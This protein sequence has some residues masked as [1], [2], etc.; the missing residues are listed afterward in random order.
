MKENP[1]RR[2][3]VGVQFLRSPCSSVRLDITMRNQ[4]LVEA[5]KRPGKVIRLKDLERNGCAHTMMP[6][7][8]GDD[9]QAS[10]VSWSHCRKGGSKLPLVRCKTVPHLAQRVTWTVSTTR[11]TVW[12]QKSRFALWPQWA[13]KLAR[14]CLW[15][16]CL[17]PWLEGTIVKL[18]KFCKNQNKLKMIQN[19][20]GPTCLR[21]GRRRLCKYKGKNPMKAVFWWLAG[22][23][24]DS[25][26]G[27]S[28]DQV[29][30]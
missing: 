27:S 15:D 13:W 23:R 30:T 17:N 8:T 4:Q 20:R 6:G 10:W 29:E 3:R 14:V 25:R 5:E 26:W 9:R 12:G 18:V 24:D 1:G 21:E 19:S 16:I 2:N 7:T 22:P 11:L 28:I